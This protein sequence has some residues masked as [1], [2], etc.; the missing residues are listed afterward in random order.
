MN[1]DTERDRR[2][3]ERYDAYAAAYQALWAPTL[4]LAAARL[5]GELSGARVNRAIDVGAG[6]GALWPDFHAAFPGAVLLA[7]DRSSGMLR[8]APAEM[9]RVVADARMLPLPSGHMDLALLLFMLFHL[10][11]PHEG[12]R[13]ARRILRPGGEAGT[14]TWGSD[15][16]S[17]AMEIWTECLDEYGAGPLDPVTLSR[18][19]LLDTPEKVTAVLQTS[20]FEMVRAWAEDLVTVIGLEHLLALKTRMGSEKVRFDSLDA[21]AR[22]QCVSDARRRMAALPAEAFTTRG[23]I[24]YAI[25]S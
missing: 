22:E 1:L 4:R 8:L 15:F 21:R 18:N 2:I 3:V 7:V 24:I 16:T 6:V 9:R 13:E 10:D 19:E 20:G 12:A 25:G 17:P 14:V 11:D 5:L 23:Q